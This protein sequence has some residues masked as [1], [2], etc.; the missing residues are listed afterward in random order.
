[1][2][3]VILPMRNTTRLGETHLDDYPFYIICFYLLIK[4]I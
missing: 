3:E 4:M 1:M 2:S